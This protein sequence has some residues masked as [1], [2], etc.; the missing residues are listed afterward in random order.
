MA[1]SLPTRVEP[2]KLIFLMWGEPASASTIAGVESISELIKLKAPGG[3]PAS[4]KHFSVSQCEFG[5]RSLDLKTTGQPAANGVATARIPRIDAAFHGAIASTGPMGSL[6]MRGTR[7]LLEI[8]IV[9]SK[10]DVVL[11]ATSFR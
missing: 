11:L 9:P 4:V 3:T 5:L 8:A 10:H 1:I 6:K 2:V 7:P